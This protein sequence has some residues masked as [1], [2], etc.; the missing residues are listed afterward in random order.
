MRLVDLTHLVRTGLEVYPGDPTVPEIIRESSHGPATHQ[1][2]SFRMG[3]HAGT[4][5]DLPLHFLDGEPDLGAFPVELCWGPA[6]V[7]DAPDGAIGAEHLRGLDLAGVDFLILRTGWEREWG[8]HRY[9]ER[10]PWLTGD[11]AELVA[12]SGLKGVGLDAPSVDPHG[13]STAHDVLASA[14]MINIENLA[15]L[16]S[17]PTSGFLLSVLPLRLDGAEASPVRAVA[18]LEAGD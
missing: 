18:V 16:S 1:S 9:Y 13:V 14:G 15:N 8:G 3:C 12:A 2:S 11:A 10:W 17:L 6:M 7:A 4:H 5:V